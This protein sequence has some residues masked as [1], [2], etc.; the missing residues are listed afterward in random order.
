MTKNIKYAEASNG[1]VS[2]AFPDATK[3]GVELLRKGGNAVDAA[4][5]AAFALGVCEPQ[6]SGLGGQTM[7]LIGSGKKVIAIDGSSRAPSL[8]HASAIYKTDRSVGYRASTVPS[9]LA[10][11]WYVH[12]RYGNLPWSN[13]LEP[14]IRVAC[15]GYK[16]TDLQQ[17]LQEQDVDQL[18][19]GPG[20]DLNLQTKPHRVKD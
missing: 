4:C 7:M 11:L 14:A 20:L 8:A 13:I 15:E 3:A 18:V 9:T 12:N 10:T 2:S 16:I 5:A 1:M 6:A 19:R 17:K